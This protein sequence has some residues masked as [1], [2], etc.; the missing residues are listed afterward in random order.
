MLI[1]TT[2]INGFLIDNFN[3]YKLEEGKTQG[4]ALYAHQIEN[5]RMK[6]LNVLLMIGNEVLVP[7]TIVIKHFNYIHIKEK[8]KAKKYM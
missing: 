2:E 7:A 6:K 5:L 3:Q 8:V 4:Y 1:E